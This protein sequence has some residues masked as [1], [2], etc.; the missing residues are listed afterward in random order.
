MAIRLELTKHDGSMVD[1]DEGS[2]LY[3][4]E[5]NGVLQI[6]VKRSPTDFRLGREYAP[7]AWV[8]VAGDRYAPST[9]GLKRVDDEADYDLL[10]SV[11]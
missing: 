1:I 5:S 10:D 6:I 8:H 9:V 11:W 3:H 7:H 2:L 4:I